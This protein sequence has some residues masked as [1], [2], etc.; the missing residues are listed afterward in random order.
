MA[1]HAIGVLPL[2]LLASTLLSAAHASEMKPRGDLAGSGRSNNQF[3]YNHDTVTPAA[4][5][6]PRPNDPE[7]VTQIPEPVTSASDPV[8]TPNP[9]SAP[10]DVFTDDPFGTS[11]PSHSNAG[12]A[13]DPNDPLGGRD[14]LA[15]DDS[16]TGVQ[17]D[18]TDSSAYAGTVQPNQVNQGIPITPNT[19]NNDTTPNFPN[20]PNNDTTPNFP[21]TPDNVTDTV[22]AQNSTCDKS[23]LDG[24]TSSYQITKH[25]HVLHWAVVSSTVVKIA[26]EAKHRSGAARGWVSVGFSKDGKMSPADAIIGNLPD[27]PIAAYSVTGYDAAS[28][29][30]NKDLWIGDDASLLIKTNGSLIVKFQRNTTDGVAPISTTAPVTVI[31]AFSADNTQPLAFHGDK[32]RGSFQV[33]FSCNGAGDVAAQQTMPSPVPVPADGA[34]VTEGSSCTQSTLSEFDHQVDLYDGKI[35]LHWK[36]LSGPVFQV[37][38]EAKHL[39]GAE[40]SWIAVGWSNNG[41]MAPADAVVGNM[42]GIKAYRLDGY[43]IAELVND[44]FSLGPNPSVTTSATGSTVVKFSRTNGDG[45]TVPINLSGETYVIW[46]F[47]RGMLEA[48]GYHD[49]NRGLAT[50]DFLCNKAPT[51]LMGPGDNVATI[52]GANVDKDPYAGLTPA[53]RADKEARRERRTAR[54]ANRGAIFRSWANAMF[55]LPSPIPSSNP[56][57]PLP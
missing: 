50:V 6:T 21:D 37:A 41:A 55:G 18:T 9:A 25:G 20:T 15:G 36:V 47:S 24:Y 26:F 14:P 51:T 19:P 38:F 16:K 33:N 54:R 5:I 8:T 39:S 23:D 31:W 11:G 43:K 42:P 32:R 13:F 17:T 34:N 12:P 46:A 30:V 29:T 1:R 7:P 2:L 3:I 40:N 10:Q 52:P 49:Y 27:S 35:L 56:S 53:E 4:V 22:V 45:G 28:I 48:F 44:T 57:S